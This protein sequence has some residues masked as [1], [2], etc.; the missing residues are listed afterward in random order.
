M[1]HSDD[2]HEKNDYG[3]DNRRI[4]RIGFTSKIDNVERN[5]NTNFSAKEDLD[6]KKKDKE[7]SGVNPIN[8]GIVGIIPELNPYVKDVKETKDNIPA[9]LTVNNSLNNANPNLSSDI[10]K[11]MNIK[12]SLNNNGNNVVNIP[13]DNLIIEKVDSKRHDD[14]GLS[15]RNR[16]FHDNKYRDNKDNRYYKDNRD[17]KVVGITKVTIIETKTETAETIIDIIITDLIKL[18]IL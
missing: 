6:E 4:R 10:N 1:S 11:D 9:I 16:D 17:N 18:S 5:N 15:N 2:K 3:I 7:V 14:F 12:E 13:K 8:P